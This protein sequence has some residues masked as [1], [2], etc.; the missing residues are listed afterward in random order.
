MVEAGCG[1]AK[2]LRHRVAADAVTGV[3]AG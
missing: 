3:E 2:A 1:V